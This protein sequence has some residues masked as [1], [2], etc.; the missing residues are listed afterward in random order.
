MTLTITTIIVVIIIS[1]FVLTLQVLNVV[2][3][4]CTEVIGGS[5]DLTPSNLTNLKCSSDFQAT[6]PEGRYIRFG[7]REHAMA[8]ICNGMFAHGGVRPYVFCYTIVLPSFS[9][10]DVSVSLLSIYCCLSAFSDTT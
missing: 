6:T 8:A 1:S 5:A 3:A 7:V 9:D 2:A 4:N 10:C